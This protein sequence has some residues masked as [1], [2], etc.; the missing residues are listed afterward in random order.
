VIR[1]WTVLMVLLMIALAAAACAPA[2]VPT[3]T[4]AAPKPPAATPTTAAP[5]PAAATPTAAPAKPTQAAPTPAPA[6]VTLKFGT[7]GSLSFG[8]VYIALE[9]G[10]FKEQGINLEVVNFRTVGELVAPLGTGQVDFVG[11]PLSSPLLAAADRGIDLKLVAD[12]S[13]QR[14]NWDPSYIV[15]RKDLAD[16]GQVKTPKDL[17][18]MKIAIPSQGGFGQMLI[19]KMLEEGGLKRD[20]VEILVVPHADQVPAFQNKAIA[21]S[22]T[23]EP[24]IVRGV[25]GGFTIRWIPDYKYFG[26][27]VEG[28]F[29]VFSPQLAKNRDVAQRWMIAYLKGVRVYLD[30]FGDKKV[31]RDEAVNTLAKYTTAN[32]PKL[33]DFMRLTYI[34]PNGQP[35]KKSTD[36]IYKYFV[37]SGEYKGTKTMNDIMDLSFAD[38]A[39]QK[40]GKQ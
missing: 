22:W 26:D 15:L 10:F 37:D 33:F 16:S 11:M 38:Y 20:D 6:P 35:D 39:V 7:T 34:D 19:D 13:Q 8:G 24:F 4:P 28:A 27:R 25:Q 2:A 40:L 1:K 32:D 12:G 29:I 36:A 9:K 5:A 31:G 18:G 17:K 14:L 30:A 21:A 3:A 23:L